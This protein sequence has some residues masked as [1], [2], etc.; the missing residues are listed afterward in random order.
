ML[1]LLTLAPRLGI[2]K[3]VLRFRIA[4]SYCSARPVTPL[5]WVPSN[6]TIAASAKRVLKPIFLLR[7]STR[8]IAQSRKVITA[9]PTAYCKTP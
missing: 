3:V 4:K 8:T 1:Q 5:V 6:A 9:L 2:D 7:N